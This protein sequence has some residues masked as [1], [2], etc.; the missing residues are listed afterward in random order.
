MAS[1]ADRP[2]VYL[3]KSSG[4][5]A[6]FDGGGVRD[7]ETDKPRFDLIR[8]VNVPYADQILT[9]WAAL[10]AR[11]AEKYAARNWEHFSDRTALDR[12]KSSAARHFEQWFNGEID[13][14]HAAAVFFNVMAVEYVRGVLDGRWPPL[15]ES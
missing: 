5:Q 15:G 12:A 14:D 1:C 9:R 10:M 7:T 13:E 3:T 11:G 8:P 6:E 2:Y 4:Q